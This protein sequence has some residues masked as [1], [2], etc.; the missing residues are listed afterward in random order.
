VQ[1]PGPP[2]GISLIVAEGEH[3]AGSIEVEE[4]YDLPGLKGC[5]TTR[6]RLTDVRVPRGN[7]LGE[8]GQG[9]D[10][11]RN[12]FLPNF[13]SAAETLNAN[14]VDLTAA[15]D[16]LFGKQAA[17]TFAAFLQAATGSQ[18]PTDDLAKALLQHDQ[19]LMQQV[20]AFAAKDYATAH[21]L[22]YTTYQHMDEM[23]GALANAFSA[24]KSA[25]APAGGPQTGG[26]TAGDEGPR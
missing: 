14:T 24:V 5:L 6:V 8:E 20:D 1:Q 12:A 23:G 19:L 7:L 13:A 17:D 18:M 21:D 22:A 3:L 4:Y 9:V 11:T 25:S 10:L 26:G 16:S 2:S 15:I